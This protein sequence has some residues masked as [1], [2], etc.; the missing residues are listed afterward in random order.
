MT[1]T[2]SP[3]RTAELLNDYKTRKAKVEAERQAYAELQAKAKAE[4]EAMYQATRHNRNDNTPHKAKVEHA[5]EVCGETIQKGTWMYTRVVT[6]GYGWPE[7]YHRVTYYR[8]KH[9]TDK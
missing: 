8:H 7:G 9:H 3:E 4:R 5:C 6:T 1:I 2:L